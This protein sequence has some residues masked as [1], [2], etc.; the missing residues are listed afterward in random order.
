MKYVL[1][2]ERY[3]IEGWAGDRIRKSRLERGDLMPKALKAIGLLPE[4]GLDMR[5]SF[6]KTGF[7]RFQIVHNGESARPKS[8]CEVF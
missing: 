8:L 6:L 3:P 4:E 2:A 1:H 7:K 5:F